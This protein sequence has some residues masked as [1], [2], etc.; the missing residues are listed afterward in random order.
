MKPNSLN[1]IKQMELIKD[2]IT[3]ECQEY[4]YY[5]PASCSRTFQKI[6]N[7]TFIIFNNAMRI[8]RNQTPIIKTK[9]DVL[10]I[11]QS[12][13]L[14]FKIYQIVSTTDFPVKKEEKIKEVMEKEF[15]INSTDLLK[16]MP[17]EE[18]E[19]RRVKAI[20]HGNI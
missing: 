18:E 1:Q 11:E 13:N 17:P 3:E 4:I 8:L 14:M 10:T 15:F 20:L 7:A 6:K 9:K 5:K 2:Y 12:K 16:T 19:Y